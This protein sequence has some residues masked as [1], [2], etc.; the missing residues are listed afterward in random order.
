MAKS[1]DS[2]KEKTNVRRIKATD[3]T[4]KKSVVKKAE[5]AKSAKQT[6]KELQKDTKSPV[7]EKK[8]RRNLF[9]RFVDYLKGSWYELKQVHWPSR[10][11]TWSMTGAVLL[12]SILFAVLIVLLDLGFDW[13][14]KQ[15]LR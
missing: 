10:S 7:S 12:F 9:T 13:L 2:N 14:F 11:V 15:L 1:S 5:N 4:E 6:T 8:V 3:T